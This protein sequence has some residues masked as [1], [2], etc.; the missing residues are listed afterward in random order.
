[1]RS[2]GGSAL[3]SEKR[4]TGFFL[5][6]REFYK[7]F[8]VMMALLVFQNIIT[9][10]VNVADNIMLGGYS[11]TALSAAAACNQI[12]YILQQFTV[13][14]LGE[15]IVILSSQYWGKKDTEMIQRISG[16]AML[17]G[18]LA[19]AALTAAAFVAPDRMVGIFADDLDI[20]RMGVSYLS[21]IR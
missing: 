9:Y 20:I 12:Q 14:G 6:S 10:S 8:F 13:M 5:H 7:S 18:I 16:T 19:G 3:S 17:C 11:Q 4:D 15:G 1:M 2:E 21:I